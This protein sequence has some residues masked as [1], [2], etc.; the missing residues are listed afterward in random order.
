MNTE[1]GNQSSND[2]FNGEVKV[3][4]LLGGRFYEGIGTFRLEGTDEY[5]I[6]PEIVHKIPIEV[7]LHV[8]GNDYLM[9]ENTD[10]RTMFEEVQGSCT[11]ET[12][13]PIA[14]PGTSTQTG[15]T[16]QIGQSADS[17][18]LLIIINRLI[19]LLIEFK[20]SL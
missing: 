5:V 9:M 17:N 2:P 8:L 7:D 3:R 10:R 1:A 11:A 20:K 15:T 19:D 18:M 16:T 13:P 6:G 14:Q 4:V 12:V